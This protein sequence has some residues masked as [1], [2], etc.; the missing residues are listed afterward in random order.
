V[1]WWAALAVAGDLESPS[2]TWAGHQVTITT[3]TVPLLGKIETRQDV[4]MLSRVVD[5]GEAITLV[6]TPCNIAIRSDGGV[7]LSFAPAA[8]QRIP[9]PTIKYQ[10]SEGGFSAS[11]SGGWAETDVDGDG[12]PGFAVRVEAPVCGGSMSVASTTANTGRAVRAEGGLDGTV[13]IDLDRRILST[14]NPCLGLVP[15][16]T[17]EHVEGTFRFRPVADGATCE[18]LMSAGWPVAVP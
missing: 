14:S 7:K 3:R 11:W 9:A 1:W 10:A 12:K 8:V 2:A 5:T 4:W 18:S 17:T 13:S 15:K 6:E 16:K